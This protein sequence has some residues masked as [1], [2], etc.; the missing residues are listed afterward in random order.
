[1][2]QKFFGLHSENAPSLSDILVQHA[3]IS[4]VNRET[5][6]PGLRVVPANMSLLMADKQVLLDVQTPQQTRLRD[7]LNAVA[8]SYD[9]CIIDNAP[10]LNMC[11]V[12]ALVASDD[13]LIPIKIDRFAFDG[14]GI[15]LDQI[16]RIR[17]S[18][19]P[20]L[21]IMGCFITIKQRNNVNGS[22]A[23][24]LQKNAGIPVFKTTIRKTVKVDEM[25]FTGKPLIDYAPNSTAT[26]DYKK[27]VEEYLQ[28]C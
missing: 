17:K 24:Y 1:M 13:V 14:L 21:Q 18:F 26:Q 5:S 3:G 7:A 15:L 19:N 28:M 9:F 10:D 25:T 23:E 12:N 22:G 27:L 16:E 2:R 20:G 4:T 6:I 11:A 8:D